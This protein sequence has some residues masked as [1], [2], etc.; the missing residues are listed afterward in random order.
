MI[1]PLA[2]FLSGRVAR[3]GGGADLPAAAGP[4]RLESSGDAVG[5]DG[6]LRGFACRR[7]PARPGGEGDSGVSCVGFV[8]RNRGSL[9]VKG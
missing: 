6:L 8:R 7:L 5:R 9:L 2:S 3:S 4:F 1:F